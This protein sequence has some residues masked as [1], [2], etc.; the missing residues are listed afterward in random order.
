MQCYVIHLFIIY[1]THSIL[2]FLF[3]LKLSINWDLTHWTTAAFCDLQRRPHLA[4]RSIIP[5]TR[6]VYTVAAGADHAA[7]HTPPGSVCWSIHTAHMC[8]HAHTKTHTNTH[9]QTQ[10]PI[11]SYTK[12]I[13]TRMKMGL[14]FIKVQY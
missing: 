3:F 9:I 10:Y 1:L 2:F 11:S 5:I 13:L 8:M 4:Y 12:P 7:R 6:C 14:I